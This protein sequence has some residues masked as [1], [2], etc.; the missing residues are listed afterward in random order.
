[1]TVPVV[2]A[3]MAGASSGALAAASSSADGLG[4]LGASSADGT[5][6]LLQAIIGP[7]FPGVL[8][9]IGPL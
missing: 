4:M 3:P 9:F 8:P 7:L 1:L 2:G 6:P 5:L